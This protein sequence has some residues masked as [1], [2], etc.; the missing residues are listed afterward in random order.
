MGILAASAFTV[1][2][3]SH[4]VKIKTPGQL[5]FGLDMIL[6]ITHESSWR[7]IHQRK[8]AQ[9]HKDVTGENSTMIDHDYRVGDQVFVRNFL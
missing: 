4:R 1:R 9:I 3:M 5:D 8:Q 7:Y 2:S 6:P